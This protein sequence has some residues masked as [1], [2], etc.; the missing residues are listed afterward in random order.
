MKEIHQMIGSLRDTIDQG[1][2]VYDNRNKEIQNEQGLIKDLIKSQSDHQL[3][4][5]KELRTL[6]SNK[7][8]N[9]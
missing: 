1:N 9:K 8:N 4:L 3:E 6:S 2:N 5:I 7:D